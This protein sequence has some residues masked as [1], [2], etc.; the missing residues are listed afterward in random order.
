MICFNF[1]DLLFFVCAIQVNL[2][3]W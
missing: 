3:Y 2:C 1:I